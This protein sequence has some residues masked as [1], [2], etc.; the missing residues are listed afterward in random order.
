M[1]PS[2]CD[3]PCSPSNVH[4]F[5]SMAGDS[6]TTVVLRRLPRDCTRE[7]VVQ[8]LDRAGFHAKYDFVYLPIDFATET[9]MS[10]AFVNIVDPGMVPSFWQAFEGFSDWPAPCAKTCR[11]TWSEAHQG[12]EAL[13]ERYRDS[14]VMHHSVPDRFRP[15]LFE[16]GVPCQFPL[17]HKAPKAPRARNHSGVAPNRGKDRRGRH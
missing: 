6:R 13:I 14:P 10:Y 3:V 9:S 8:L 4:Q 17:P 5:G 11:V 16:D 1:S 7:L 15:Q 12:R 2:P